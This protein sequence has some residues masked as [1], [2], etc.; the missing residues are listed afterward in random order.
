MGSTFSA[1]EMGK[2]SLFAH[3][4]SMQTAGHNL[5][6]SSTE[7]YSRQRV[8]LKATDPLYRPDLS[9]EETPG[10]IGQ[11]VSVGSIRR[12]RDELLDQRIVAQTNQEGYWKTR[13]NYIL[14]MEQIYNEPAE[15]S[16]RT[17]MDQFWDSWEELSLYPESRSAR[18]AVL[19]RGETLT[20]AIHQQYR[21]LKAIRDII[22]G[23]VE[24]VVRQ[25]ND[26]S[27][28][29]A[30]VN[31][32]IVKVRAMGD[33]PNDL[34]DRRD[35]L[36]EKLSGLINITTDQR[37]PD[38]FV[39]HTDGIELV[40]GKTFRTFELTGGIENDGY[41]RVIWSDTGTTTN[42]SGGTLGA[43]LELRDGD[44]RDEIQK[45]DTMTMSFV[46]LVNDIHRDGMGSNG[47]TGVDFFVEQS[48]IN[49]IAG[50]FDRNGDG[51]FDS[52]YLYRV[53]GGNK[54]SAREQI[55]LEGTLTLSAASGTVDVPYFST[56]MVADVVERINNAG[57]EVVASLDRDGRLVL[58]GTTAS[59]ADNPDF[60]IRYMA[61]SGR[62]LAGYA[63][64][65]AAPG[66]DN[67]YTWEQANAVNA[68]AG[69]E[70][71]WAVAPIAHPAGW[72][73]VNNAIKADVQT[74]AAGF[75]ADDGVVFAGDNRAAVAIAAIRN[76]PVM[77]G[78]TRTF[79]DYFADAVTNIGLK[80]EQAERSLE[81]QVTI[82]TELRGMRD[83]ISGVNVDE[84]LADIIKFQHGYN[85]A[86]RF[87]ATFNEM[88]DTVINRM[89]V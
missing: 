62:F 12:V 20:D 60:V 69:D 41:G 4:Q 42:F 51:E 28:Q 75:P 2:R 7:G 23:D 3:S 64:V 57:A 24:G 85:A 89:G 70:L 1:I 10:Q 81:T 6:N 48:F 9:R 54:L 83:A 50:N 76:T 39:V 38:E 8:E 82:M 19:A 40:Q 84:E 53:S 56:D 44:V 21:G 18:Q 26:L 55:G 49:N 61:D 27:R 5:S 74:I 35:L 14:M 17:R 86:A 78:N 63:G 66:V 71:A 88:L 25:V 15:T 16:V 33:S 43:L 72:M 29:I 58:K 46:D 37:D 80:G 77:V 73:E 45:L 68:L 79:D 31:E 59:N 30:A 87:I 52:S 65:L 67:A 13:D 32:E 34:M 47:K 11:G 36:V 22:H